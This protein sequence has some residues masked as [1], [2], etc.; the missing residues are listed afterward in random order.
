MRK[1]IYFLIF[2]GTLAFLIRVSFISKVGVKES[3]DGLLYSN[4][5]L[6]LLQG[7]GFTQ[8]IRSYEFIVP[9]LYP[10]FL[11][12]V[13]LLFG[14][15]NYLSVV[16]IQSFFSAIT[17]L[18]IYLIGKKLFNTGVGVLSSLYFAIY[19]V[20]IW[21]NSYFLTETIYT[22]FLVLFVWY[23][24]FLFSKNK[25]AAGELI[26]S[27]VIWGLCNLVRPNIIL[28]FPFLLLWVFLIHKKNYLK[29]FSLIFLGMI[30]II[31]PWILYVYTSYGIIAPIG[32]YG[33]EQVWL[34][35]NE[36]MN[37]N[38][39]YSGN[40]YI[41]NSQFQKTQ[42]EIIRL[43]QCE[44][45]RYIDAQ[46]QDVYKKEIKDFIINHPNK[47]ILNSLKKYLTF[48]K[49]VNLNIS[50]FE[51]I[52]LFQELNEPINRLYRYLIY[53]LPIGILLTIIPIIYKPNYNVLILFILIY[54]SLLVSSAIIVYG[55]R[56]RLP[57]MPFAIM[58]MFS[59]IVEVFKLI[60]NKFRIRER[61]FKILH[62]KKSWQDRENQ[63]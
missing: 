48:W 58:Y 55:A 57:I 5:A 54:Y 60:N 23:L 17:C 56:Y 52:P 51:S 37:P 16:I 62:L 9:P 45:Y 27:G 18:L 61:F 47:F 13:Y 35:N 25:I 29:Y 32:S 8:T 2:L 7:E 50:V 3:A 20:S 28:F 41:D 14:I 59:P 36:F 4:I 43:P 33:L 42:Q 10:L 34:G 44:K 53:L 11:T 24:I 46:C 6:N 49:P 1:Q 39:Y 19:P 30:I 63:F 26:F 38:I 40:L 22:F 15:E 21:W 31:A 12:F